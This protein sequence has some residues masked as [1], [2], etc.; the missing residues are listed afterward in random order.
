M[1]TQNITATCASPRQE[2][3]SVGAL[4]RAHLLSRLIDPAA[5][6]FIRE[7]IA[8]CGPTDVHVCDGS[9]AEN[10]AMLDVLETTGEPHVLPV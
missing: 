6:A 5:A 2:S 8:L 1:S 10:Q 3:S 4:K 7:A 9:A